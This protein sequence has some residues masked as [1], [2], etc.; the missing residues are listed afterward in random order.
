MSTQ[1]FPAPHSPQP[2]PSEPDAGAANGGVPAQGKTPQNTPRHTA[3]L[4]T[5]YRIAPEW[6]A[7]GGLVASS[8]RY[9][10]NFETSEIA[11][12][13]RYDATLAYIQKA[14]EVRLSLQ[15]ITDKTYFEA[16]SGGRAVPV[17]GRT[18]I[19]TGTFRY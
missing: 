2:P 4:W 19:V 16:A 3:S 14:Y 11:G 9:V 1:P 17:R 8:K 6:E 10:N 5:T 18:A 15:N 12:Y 7:G 13:K